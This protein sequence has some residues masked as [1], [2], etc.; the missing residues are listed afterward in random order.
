LAG[1]E[2]AQSRK[3]VNYPKHA[4]YFDIVYLLGDIS[5]L[6]VARQKYCILE[7]SRECERKTILRRKPRVSSQQSY[8][9]ADLAAI[10]VYN[11]QAALRQRGP[12]LPRYVQH[13]RTLDRQ[14]HGKPVRQPQQIL[15]QPHLP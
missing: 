15:Q 3:L 8:S 14:S 7:A 2:Q 9:L 10:Q 6:R 11:F 5:E 12:F 4:V 1:R 13:L